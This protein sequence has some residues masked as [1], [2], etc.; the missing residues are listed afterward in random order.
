MI[1]NEFQY[2]LTRKRAEEF[3]RT[4]DCLD[5][6]DETESA[7][8][9]HPLLRQAERAALAS[10]LES[11]RDEIAEYESRPENMRQRVSA[12]AILP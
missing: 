9:A 7:S 12:M 5:A 1:E 4:L 8:A 2:H 6:P 10:Q 11:L 3:A